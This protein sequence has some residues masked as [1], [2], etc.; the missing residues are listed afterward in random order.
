MR[1][2]RPLQSPVWRDGFPWHW[3]RFAAFGAPE[4]C[5]NGFLWQ[6]AGKAGDGE[7]A[8]LY[9][10]LLLIFL[11]DRPFFYAFLLLFF[12][13]ALVDT[14]GLYPHPLPLIS[15]LGDSVE[16]H[17]ALGVFACGCSGTPLMWPPT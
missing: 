6:L 17:R 7:P 1:K 4:L 12:C 2:G 10:Q 5:S 3:W 11:P 13:V 15:V 14:Q 16:G 9:L 8:P